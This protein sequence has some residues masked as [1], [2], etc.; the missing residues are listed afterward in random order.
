MYTLFF[1]L[2]SIMAYHRILNIIP[3]AN[4]D[5]VVYPSCVFCILCSLHLLIPNSQSIPASFPLPLGNHKYV[6]YICESASLD[7]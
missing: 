7:N 5:L 3:S 1:I 6:L 2:F 4:Q